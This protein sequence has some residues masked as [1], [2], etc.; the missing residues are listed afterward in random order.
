MAEKKI[1][2]WMITIKSRIY[3]QTGDSF[4][5]IGKDGEYGIPSTQG[6]ANFLMKRY[7]KL[8]KG[9]TLNVAKTATD[10]ENRNILPIMKEE[11]VKMLRVVNGED[12]K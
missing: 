9:I 3:K 8:V 2:G 1:R 10:L 11:N 4:G 7:Y 5:C 6:E 12:K